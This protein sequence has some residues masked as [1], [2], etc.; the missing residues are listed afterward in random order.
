MSEVQK[1][2]EDSAQNVAVRYL[3]DLNA[4]V[5]FLQKKCAKCKVTTPQSWFRVGVTHIE[6]Q[7]DPLELLKLA[8]RVVLCQKCGN[9]TVTN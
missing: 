7:T 9:I 5:E 2:N 1:E 3:F 4:S 8:K 6:G